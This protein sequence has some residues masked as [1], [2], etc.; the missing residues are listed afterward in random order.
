MACSGSCVIL[1]LTR[2]EDEYSGVSKKTTNWEFP[3]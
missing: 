1:D 2:A 3:G